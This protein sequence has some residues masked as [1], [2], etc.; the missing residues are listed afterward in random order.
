[1]TDAEL[2]VRV[3]AGDTGAFDDLVARHHAACLRYAAH[4][5]GDRMEAE[6]VVQ[7]TL[8]RAYRS[9]GRY[10]ER[11]QFRAWLFRILV[12]RCRTA[13]KRMGTNRHR[14]AGGMDPDTLMVTGPDRTATLDLREV[15]VRA[16]G[17]L[18]EPHRE[19]FLLKL[20][21]GL[22]YDEISRIT[23]ASVP[24]L[25]MRVKRARDRLRDRWKELD[26]DGER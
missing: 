17:E 15:L 14:T 12:N 11:D 21:E 2:V 19:A 25:K 26:D 3:V 10:Q 24:A 4:V 8:L 9:L 7:D 5:L 6:D 23:G 1:M 13:G 22:E 20:G 16:I 18:D